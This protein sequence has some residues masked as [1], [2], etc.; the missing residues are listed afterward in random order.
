VE[1]ALIS[2]THVRILVERMNLEKIVGKEQGSSITGAVSEESMLGVLREFSHDQVFLEDLE[3]FQNSLCTMIQSTL[4]GVEDT[5][6]D[7]EKGQMQEAVKERTGVYVHTKGVLSQV[8]RAPLSRGHMGQFFNRESAKL[9]PAMKASTKMQSLAEWRDRN[10]YHKTPWK[11]YW[12]ESARK[13]RMAHDTGGSWGGQA[14]GTVAGQPS[15]EALL[16]A[17]REKVRKALFQRFDNITSAFAAMDHSSKGVV[18]IADFKKGIADLRIGL[19]SQEIDAL[20]TA[21]QRDEFITYKDFF[22]RYATAVENLADIAAERAR[23]GVYS[24]LRRD[25]SHPEGRGGKLDGQL[26]VQEEEEDADRRAARAAVGLISQD[27]SPPAR[28]AQV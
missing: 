9:P 18:S 27:A 24:R 12:Q 15:A 5:W 11:T 25:L 14:N 7:A 19:S 2:P 1:R 22:E 16:K 10:V 26:T 8:G 17:A 28:G 6:Y 13:V 20:I 4:K 3:L 21:E 23:K